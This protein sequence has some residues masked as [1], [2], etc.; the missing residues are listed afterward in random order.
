MTMDEVE[1]TPTSYLVCEVVDEGEPMKTHEIQ[2]LLLPTSSSA[3]L[4]NIKLIV[5]SI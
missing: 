5:T 3:N 4:S 1:E 2:E